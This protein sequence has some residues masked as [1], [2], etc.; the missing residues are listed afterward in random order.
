MCECPLTKA[1][2]AEMTLPIREEVTCLADVMLVGRRY[3][4]VGT[5]I[6]SAEDEDDFDETHARAKEGR[7][8][9]ISPDFDQ[10]PARWTINTECE[11]KTVGAVRDITTIHG[12]LAIAA[13]SKVSI[14][15]YDNGTGLGK[16]LVEVSSFSSTFVAQS[17]CIS[18]PSKQKAEETL[19]VGDGLRSV[20]ILDV[21]EETGKIWSDDRDM[22][23]HQVSTLSTITDQGPGVVVADVCIYINKAV[24]GLL[25]LLQGFSNVLTFRLRDRIEP[26]ATFGLHEEVIRFQ[27]GSFA[28]PT[29]ASEVI[30]PDLVFA[31]YDGRLGMIGELS[32]PAAKVLDDLQRNMDKYHKGPGGISW[33]TFRK[34]GTPLVQRDTAGFVDGDL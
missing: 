17:L 29:S 28:P 7:V 21:D 5:A 19:I 34:G 2:L 11:I 9:L 15:R 4:A 14:H 8:L 25:T 24:S 32:D 12:F 27:H 26:A 6:H 10:P 18:P 13:A 33:R 1:V 23:T 20:L 30:N 31:T 16:D 22:A 3:I